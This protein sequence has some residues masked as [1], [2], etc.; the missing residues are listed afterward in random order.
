MLLCQRKDVLNRLI[1]RNVEMAWVFYLLVAAEFDRAE[2][3]GLIIISVLPSRLISIGW[4]SPMV[5]WLACF[6]ASKC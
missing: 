4:Q 5:A 2:S 6:Q 3:Q 1:I